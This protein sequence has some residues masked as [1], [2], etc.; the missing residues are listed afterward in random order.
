MGI[1]TEPI[2][3]VEAFN[4][5]RLLNSGLARLRWIV[6]LLDSLLAVAGFVRL[7]IGPGT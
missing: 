4:L 3:V 6:E 5:S 2:V 7:G 1:C